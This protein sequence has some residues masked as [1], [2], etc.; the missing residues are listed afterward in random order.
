MPLSAK[1]GLHPAG[2]EF[3]EAA[4]SERLPHD[5]GRAEGMDNFILA[6]RFEA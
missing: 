1:R 5:G 6:L 3:G 2:P 4:E